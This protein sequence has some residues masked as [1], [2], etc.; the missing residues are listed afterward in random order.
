MN[1]VWV[2]V[3]GGQINAALEEALTRLDSAGSELVLDFSSVRRID[4]GALGAL[5]KLAGNAD[6]RA[7][8]V[9]LC[10]V[11][12]DVYKVL[13]LIKLAGRFSFMG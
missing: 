1:S 9:V 3:D 12:A 10:G 11:H 13:K 8:K 2:N 5:E 4:A 7:V 6:E